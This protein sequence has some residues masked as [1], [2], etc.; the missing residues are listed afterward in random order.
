[1]V[2]LSDLFDVDSDIMIDDIYEDSRCKVNNGLFFAIKGLK[3]NGNNYIDE[4][5]NNGAVCVVSEDD[6]DCSVLVIRVSDCKRVYNEVL[7]KF[8]NY[9]CNSLNII[10]VTGTDG[11][12]TVTEIL[13]QLLDNCG[14]IGTNGIRYKNFE[15]NNSYTTPMPK[16]LFRAFD[17]FYRRGCKYVSMESSSERLGTNRLIG[18]DFC[19]SIFTNLTRDH[20]DVHGSMDEYAKAKAL[21]FKYLK[22]GGLGIINFDDEY[23]DYFINSCSNYVTYSSNDNRAD[24]YASD[25]HVYYN[26]LEFDINGIFGKHH[27]VSPLSGEFNVYN[28]MCCIVCLKYF[29]YSIL[30]IVDKIKQLKPIE[31]RQDF[32]KS[33]FGFS[34]M[35][36]YAHTASAIKNLVKYVRTFVSGNIIV[37]VGA[38]GDRDARRMIDIANFCT[39]NVFY[40]FFTIDNPRDD[41]P[42][43]LLNL[44]V[45]YVD[46]CNYELV[47]DRDEAIKRAVLKAGKDDIILLLGK[48]N[49]DYQI[50]NGKYVKRL[51][52]MES[53]KVCLK[54]LQ[55]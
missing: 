2:R 19:V 25:I 3:F 50:V 13:Y 36:D 4:A 33:D 55:I 27:I 30:H 43:S 35:V 18:V 39:R 15:M 48:G 51:T 1:M 47:V 28:L 37:V 23:K 20:L 31:S 24:V 34:V 22:C 40:S 41:D 12:T 38:S 14:Y 46:S 21:S 16:D 5:I 8:Y 54:S 7:K 49:E 10:S 9:S 6:I 17:E 32:I 42:I 11:K 52:D 53:V 26:F 44:M 45:S 29:G